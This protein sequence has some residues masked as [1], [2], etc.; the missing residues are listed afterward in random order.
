M[1]HDVLLTLTPCESTGVCLAEKG[2]P[3]C[4]AVVQLNGTIVCELLPPLVQWTREKA[5]LNGPC[6]TMHVA[7]GDQR[8][9]TGWKDALICPDIVVTCLR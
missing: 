7:C 4:R 5:V 3:P 2:S 1:A 9:I 8:R 6:R